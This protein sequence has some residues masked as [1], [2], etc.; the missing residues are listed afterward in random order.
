MLVGEAD[1]LGGVGGAVTMREVTKGSEAV[2]DSLHMSMMAPVQCST[3]QVA[4]GECGASASKVIYEID[5]NPKFKADPIFVTD[6]LDYTVQIVR[7]GSPSLEEG[8][9]ESQSVSGIFQLAY[10]GATTPLLNA[11]ASAVEM[12][13]ALE[14]LEGVETVTVS[15][16]FGFTKIDGVAVDGTY[17]Y[18]GLKCSAGYTCDFYTN[19]MQP[20]DLVMVSG[21]W[22]R[23]A[24]TYVD[25]ESYLPLAKVSDSSIQINFKTATV[26]NAELYGWSKGYEWTVTFHKVSG[27][28]A[29]SPLT[30]P[31]HT[32]LPTDTSVAIRVED[33]DDCLY[34]SGLTPFTQYY[35]RARTFNDFGASSTQRMSL[36]CPCRFLASRR[37]SQFR[38]CQAKSS[39]SFS[40]PTMPSGSIAQYTVQWDYDYTFKNAETSVASCSTTGYGSCEVDG[41]A[42]SLT[43]PY[44]Y[45]INHLTAGKEYYIRVAARNAVP[46]QSVDP[47]GEI[48]DNTNWCS[49][50]DGVPANQVP[51]MPG[52]V[53]LIISARSRLMVTIEPPARDGGKNITSYV[54]EYDTDSSFGSSAYITSTLSATVLDNL[55][56]GGPLV[57][58]IEDLTPGYS[59]YVRVSAVNQIGSSLPSYAATPVAPMGSPDEPSLVTVDVVEVQDTPITEMTVMWDAPKNTT[60]NGGSAVDGY[61]VEWWTAAVVEEVQEV[62]LYWTTLVN[63]S[64]FKVLFGPTYGMNSGVSTAN[65]PY[66]VA[67]YNL[68]YELMNI[69]QMQ[70]AKYDADGYVIGDVS[71]ARSSIHNQN[72]YA[73]TV[74]FN[75]VDGLNQGDQQMLT[76]TFSNDKF[77][78]DAEIDVV[79]L[80]R[81][82]RS[83]G[84]SEVQ[85]V[86]I[87]GTGKTGNANNTG[88]PVNGFFRL[89]FYGSSYSQYLPADCSASLMEDALELLS[90][91][92]QVTVTRSE[93]DA[94]ELHKK[95]RRQWTYEWRVTF[96]TNVGNLPAIIGDGTYLY[97]SNGNAEL[98]ILDGDNVVVE[99]TGIKAYDTVVGESPV[100]YGSQ[101]VGP[102]DRSFTIP[103]LTPGTEYFVYVSTKNA[104]GY[105]PRTSSLPT[106]LAPPKQ[107]PGLPNDVT[108][109]VNDGSADS[110]VVSYT[111][112]DS[113]GGD[114]IIRYRVELD[115]TDTFDAPVVQ[116]DIECS[117]NNKRT[118]WEIK[119][120][121]SRRNEIHG[122]D[123][124]ENALVYSDLEWSWFKL[125][126]SVNDQDYVTD[127]IP[128]DAV[129][130]QADEVGIKKKVGSLQLEFDNYGMHAKDGNATVASGAL[131]G[132]LFQGDRVMLSNSNNP[133]DIYTVKKIEYG[134]N[135]YSK[136]GLNFK[137]ASPRL[138]RVSFVENVNVT[139]AYGQ[140]YRV[141]GGRGVSGM[142]RIY[143]EKGDLAGGCDPTFSG[144]MQAK[145]ETISDAI[146]SGVNVIRT[147]PSDENGYTW[148]VT[149]LDDSPA[150][151][152]DY[153]ISLETNNLKGNAS[154]W[155]GG[156]ITDN[157]IQGYTKQPRVTITQL[158]EGEVYDACTG[159]QV[160]PS[161]GGLV[162][163]TEY[164]ARV[165]AINAQGY[166]ETQ[167]ALSS[168]APIVSPGKPTSV[169]LSVVSSDSLQIVFNAPTDDGGDD[170]TA[171]LVEWSTSST[172]TEVDSS[173]VTYLDGGAPFYK[174]ISGLTAGVSYYVRVS[175]YNS[176]GY[177]TS[178]A[179]TPTNYNP[180]EEPGAPTNVA[181]GVTSDSMITVSFDEP[182]DNGGDDI[183]SYYVEWDTSSTFNSLTRSPDKGTATVDATEHNSYTITTLTENTVYFVRV[184]AINDMGTGTSQTTSPASNFPTKQV[185]GKPHT[186]EV[187]SGGTSGEIDI[188]WQY[189][190]VPHHEFRARVR[191]R[192]LTI[193]QVP[194]GRHWQRALAAT[195]SKSMKSNTTK[196]QTS[197]DRMV[198]C[199][200]PT[201]R[202]SPS[203]A[204]RPGG[205]ITSVCSLATALR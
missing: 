131:K 92:G 139:S 7:I 3:S 166:G 142:S 50:V 55:Y 38:W 163:G 106:S 161:T 113:D 94:N 195:P 18:A 109:T 65:M 67:D 20:N 8:V 152:Y 70:G 205:F 103:D 90:T 159:S 171:Y 160:V 85:V 141:H 174:T 4:S 124:P 187:A 93:I 99:E 180:M 40:P 194:W 133:D 200:L 144:S 30:S 15:R 43:P 52:D 26:K 172:F 153:A 23:I 79:E 71:V 89:G 97:T 61:L 107:V 72:G 24:S 101:L 129:A 136:T 82:Q 59:Y 22:Y 138:D 165:V 135:Q 64:Q 175:A 167:A 56:V 178:A 63:N 118:V 181:L 13:H 149:F 173:L 186:I 125:K 83:H 140:V 9:F 128:Y 78:V 134:A 2:G 169:A 104:F 66:S 41:S 117:T 116:Q 164:F 146:S 158:K 119:T 16:N 80:T 176:Q 34:V 190:R 143:C 27:S 31:A 191:P 73:W 157:K 96:D 198:D 76:A 188:Q 60:G 88:L 100:E 12:K 121:G 95:Y 35:V 137:E 84:N 49:T 37:M 81:G 148:R 132:V 53:S 155:V 77:D 25:G 17:G 203:R 201:V 185:P 179:S 182:T 39:K 102:D 98:E 44:A 91:V 33:C 130:M 145:L 197:L 51:N 193:A 21:E 110:L 54:V 199:R 46:V 48:V 177:G 62:R 123:Y 162:T 29:I 184:S 75:D 32:L 28:V 150:D 57:T 204:S 14:S 1:L 108:V 87:A 47:T 10:E 189:P 122:F 170:I 36:Q 202:R 11:H 6:D 112:P 86:R 19:G 45:K 151:P 147:G 127:E 114:K 126:L 168:Q 192:I 74:T 5:T 42:I 156:L 196:M 154:S 58:Y 183:I 111:P 69:G 120:E 105:S 68:R 115:P